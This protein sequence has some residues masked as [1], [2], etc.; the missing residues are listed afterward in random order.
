MTKQS[1]LAARLALERH[2]RGWSQRHLARRMTDLAAALGI[3]LPE[4]SSLIK[5]IGNWENGRYRPRPPYPMLLARAFDTTPAALF[6]PREQAR[7]APAGGGR[8]AGMSQA[9]DVVLSDGANA[10]AA[11]DL[12]HE[13]VDHYSDRLALAPTPRDYKDLVAIRLRAGTLLDKA[14]TGRRF[15]DLAS[16]T[17]WIS[18]LLATAANDLGDHPSALVWCVDADRASGKAGAPEIAGWTALT[19]AMIAYY[20]G[21]P[22]KSAG[23]AARGLAVAPRGTA[24]YARLAAQEMRARAMAHDLDGMTSARERATIA[25]TELRSD[26]AVRGV[27]SFVHNG[28]EPPYTATSMLLLGQFDE[29]AS[30]TRSLIETIYPADDAAGGRNLSSYARMLLILGLA[31]AGLG[32]IEAA[33]AAGNAALDLSPAWSTLVL[34]R[35]LD[36]AL[37]GDGQ[38]VI[39]YH[40]RYAEAAHAHRQAALLAA[41]HRE[42]IGG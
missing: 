37:A 24:A 16:A 18:A 19:R 11:V 17:G 22:V 23:H 7:P 3:A 25:I 38:D 40:D 8:V 28:D 6:G 33:V 31:E 20:Q 36:K 5:S 21:N 26:A 9:L 10:S 34:A 30:M 32:R 13:L 39:D 42:A 27:F 29:A 4:R 12:L 15:R 14:G 41:D 2:R 1:E 35:R